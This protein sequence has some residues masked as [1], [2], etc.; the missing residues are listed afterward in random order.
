ME[1]KFKVTYES[2]AMEVV[3]IK[4]ECSL[5]TESPDYSI[6]PGN[7]FSGNPDETVW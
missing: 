2:P 1:R 7:P 5:L 4:M 6:N 3:E